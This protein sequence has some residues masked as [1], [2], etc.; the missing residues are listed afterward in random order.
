MM[1][2]AL[3][4]PDELW[5][6]IAIFVR[7]LPVGGRRSRF[8][9]CK[10]AFVCKRLASIFDGV[11]F[12][13]LVIP[14]P[15]LSTAPLKGDLP[16]V[17]SSNFVLY[18]ER[19]SRL[20]S[21]VQHVTLHMQSDGLD[22]S[23]NAHDSQPDYDSHNSIELPQSLLNF[24]ESLPK[25]KHIKLFCYPGAM[26]GDT[27]LST[28]LQ[29]AD[30]ATLELHQVAC[31]QALAPFPP[32]TNMQ[33]LQFQAPYT[34]PIQPN[35]L[36]QLLL[37]CPN[38]Q[39]CRLSGMS[40]TDYACLSALPKSLRSLSMTTMS[41]PSRNVKTS[42]SQLATSVNSLQLPSLAILDLEIHP[43][44]ASQA[45]LTS[46]RAL[47]E[48]LPTLQVLCLPMPFLGSPSR[49][50]FTLIGPLLADQDSCPLLRCINFKDRLS[51]PWCK[52]R[53]EWPKALTDS[54]VSRGL[55]EENGTRWT[56][57]LI[58]GLSSEIKWI[59]ACGVRPSDSTSRL[60]DL[61]TCQQ[62]LG[63]KTETDE[64]EVCYSTENLSH[65]GED[66]VT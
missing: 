31:S 1:A 45:S 51:L 35:M 60:I 46:L 64:Q 18:S 3:D 9:L 8:K 34:R 21:H 36:Q 63:Y 52:A 53:G 28:V 41:K 2:H 27:A 26:S 57:E 37:S 4:L 61:T 29:K 10:E 40:D 32:Q 42:I 11:F 19:H 17:D 65:P 20:L 58:E 13:S 25:L 59:H 15:H 33:L 5:V 7:D 62:Q 14:Y 30:V 44:F 12:Y 16:H 48:G 55:C 47:L 6:D 50:L 24:L 39:C 23:A 43:F 66:A 56:R 22:S 49:Y 54:F 38:L